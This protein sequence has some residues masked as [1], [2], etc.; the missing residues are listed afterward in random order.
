M[1][2]IM[3][4]TGRPEST[5]DRWG[6]CRKDLGF[7]AEKPIMGSSSTTHGKAFAITRQSHACSRSVPTSIPP[8][9]SRQA[10]GV[11]EAQVMALLSRGEIRSIAAQLPIAA[12]TD[13]AG[14]SR[15]T[16]RYAP[17]AR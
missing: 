15:M 1:G 12:E 5:T 7:P 16:R 13:L 17:C 11:S 2:C 8:A 14:S 10:A 9:T 3:A 4:W 6:G